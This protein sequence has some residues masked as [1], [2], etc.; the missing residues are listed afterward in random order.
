[1][2]SI[3]IVVLAYAILFGIDLIVTVMNP[4]MKYLELNPL[5]P[6]PI[7]GLVVVIL[8]NIA[9]LFLA[10]WAYK[11]RSA[12]LRYII[13]YILLTL[14]MVRITVI[15][16]NVQALLNPPT[17]SQAIVFSQT[18]RTVVARKVYSQ[19]II[20]QLMPYLAAVISFMLFRKDHKVIL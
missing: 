2:K 18:A 19:L 9:V 11:K 15:I 4:L 10:V 13:L 12:D 14:C 8:L 7:T 5:V 17:L 20:Q 6:N 16:N 1:M 3:E